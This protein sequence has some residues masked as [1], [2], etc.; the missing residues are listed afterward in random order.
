MSYRFEQAYET[1]N[2]P[3]EAQQKANIAQ[4]KAIGDLARKCLTHGDF[5]QYKEQ[6]EKAYSGILDA[7]ISYKTEFMSQANGDIAVYAMKLSCYLQKIQ[8]LKLLIQQVERDTKK[9]VT[10]GKQE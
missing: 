4:I 3:D 2:Q 9:G 1:S 7:M 5:H 8:D 10:N 6:Y